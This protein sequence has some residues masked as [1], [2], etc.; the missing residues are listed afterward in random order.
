MRKNRAEA[1]TVT[2]SNLVF[3][4]GRQIAG[5]ALAARLPSC[6]LSKEAVVAGALVSF[7]GRPRV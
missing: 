7:G 2:R 1:L 3:T 4:L 6:G 5:L